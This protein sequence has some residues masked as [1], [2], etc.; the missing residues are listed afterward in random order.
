MWKTFL[1]RKHTKES[2][3]LMK[4][5]GEQY[6]KGKKQPKEMIEKRAS[7]IRGR[8]SKKKGIKLSEETKR[9]IKINNAK[10][11]LGKHHSEETKQ[12]LREKHKLQ[13]FSHFYKTY[14]LTSP[15]GKI[16]IINNGLGKFAKKHNLTRSKLTPGNSGKI[17]RHKGWLCQRME[18]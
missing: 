9:K 3:L 12:K 13:D 7:K 6:W 5:N 15:K 16:F 2:I 14:K 1:G 8:P 18:E 11:W 4:K 10:Y 17:N